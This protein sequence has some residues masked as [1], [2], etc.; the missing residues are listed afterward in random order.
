[1]AFPGFQASS[2]ANLTP[3]LPWAV[4]EIKRCRR[5]TWQAVA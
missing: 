5:R 3:M 1:M 4:L 2:V